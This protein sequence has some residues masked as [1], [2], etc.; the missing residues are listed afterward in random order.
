[1]KARFLFQVRRAFWVVEVPHL[2]K[3]DVLAALQP[4]DVPRDLRVQSL[5]PLRERRALTI[6]VDSDEYQLPAPGHE[7]VVVA[8]IF[9]I[10]IVVSVVM[11]IRFDAEERVPYFPAVINPAPMVA[12]AVL[13]LHLVVVHEVFEVAVDIGLHCFFCANL[14]VIGKFARVAAKAHIVVMW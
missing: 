14:L 2:E 6:G 5:Q 9:V 4:P 1:M 8:R 12:N 13:R 3:R 11:L 7:H 10:L